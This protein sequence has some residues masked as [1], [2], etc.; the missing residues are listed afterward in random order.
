MNDNIKL[1]PKYGVNPAIPKC[2][3]CWKDKNMIILAGHIQEKG[4]NGRPIPGSD[5]EAPHGKVWDMEPCDECADYMKQG[6]IL[7]SVK[8]EER[9]DN[10]HRTGGFAVVTDEAITRWLGETET[11]KAVLQKRV[12][13]VPDEAWDKL[14]LSR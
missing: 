7:L 3:F 5:L 1:S 6:V 9:T 11:A 4:P 14:G 12:L 8:E 13:F 10:P 2:F